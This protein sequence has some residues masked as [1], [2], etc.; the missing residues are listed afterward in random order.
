MNNCV[1]K[2]DGFRNWDNTFYYTDTDSMI[3]SN[4]VLDLLQNETVEFNTRIG[5]KKVNKYDIKTEYK[6]MIQDF[7]NKINNGSNDY[8]ESS[9]IISE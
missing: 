2:F 7:K 1:A 3:I 6:K 8:I 4:H 9:Q 5:E